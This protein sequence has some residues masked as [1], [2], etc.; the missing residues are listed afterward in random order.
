M[1]LENQL[2]SAEEIVMA[3]PHFTEGMSFFVKEKR[4]K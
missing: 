1:E 3:A 4:Y 2:A